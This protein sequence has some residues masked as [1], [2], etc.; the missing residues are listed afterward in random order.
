[1]A[2]SRIPRIIPCQDVLLLV[3]FLVVA[4]ITSNLAGGMRRQAERAQRQARE[5]RAAARVKHD[6]VVTV[7]EVGKTDDGATFLAMELVSLSAYA[8]TG[9][10]KREVRSSEAA[11]ID[12]FV[13]DLARQG[14]KN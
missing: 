5:A 2:L 13:A 12:G 9:Y 6:H 7:Y 4:V 11:L 3:P 14:A 8:M 1:M 10:L